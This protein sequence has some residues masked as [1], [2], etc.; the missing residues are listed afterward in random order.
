MENNP[1]STP[2]ELQAQ[3]IQMVKRAIEAVPRT[4]EI[5]Q[6]DR[7]EDIPHTTVTATDVDIPLEGEKPFMSIED[8]SRTI[9]G[10]HLDIW[11]FFDMKPDAVQQSDKNKLRDIHNWAWKN[12]SNAYEALR[13]LNDLALQYGNN[14]L[15][16]VKLVRFYS[17]IK[18][19]NLSEKFYGNSQT[20]EN[21]SL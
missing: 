10:V 19:L 4:A 17:Q 11:E 1:V 2:A 5:P 7:P 21:I 15:G 8:A 18:M 20:K 13:K 3:R 6:I 14:A 12:C 16:E 9:D